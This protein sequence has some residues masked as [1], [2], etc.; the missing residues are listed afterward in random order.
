M[1]RLS[2]RAAVMV[3]AP[4]L[5]VILVGGSR[6]ASASHT[7]GS[8]ASSGISASESYGGR[9]HGPDHVSLPTGRSHGPDHVAVT[10]G[11]DH[12]PGHVRP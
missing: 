9:N 6:V 8:N 11:R 2:R 4:T 7:N 3:A 1:R 5:A 10:S 12:G